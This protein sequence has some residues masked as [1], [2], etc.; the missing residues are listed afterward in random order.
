VVTTR[1]DW[2]VVAFVAAGGSAFTLVALVAWLLY[3]TVDPATG[4]T[5]REAVVSTLPLN[6]MTVGAAVLL[7]LVVTY[8]VVLY[9]A[10]S[11]PIEAG[12]GY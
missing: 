1:R 9:S 12:E 4:L 10:F 5:V 8:F 3:P 11:G 7:P 6:L 2:F